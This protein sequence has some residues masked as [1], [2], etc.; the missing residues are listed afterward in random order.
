MRIVCTTYKLDFQLVFLKTSD[1]MSFFK[2]LLSL[3]GEIMFPCI[4]ITVPIYELNE[5]VN[6]SCVFVNGGRL[7][8]VCVCPHDMCL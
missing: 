4:F 3:K 5:R 2:I 7:N 1:N 6:Y 8:P